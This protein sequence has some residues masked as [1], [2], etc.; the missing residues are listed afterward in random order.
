MEADAFCEGAAKRPEIRGQ[1]FRA[2]EV[3]GVKASRHRVPHDNINEENVPDTPVSA[4][5]QAYQGLGRCLLRQRWKSR[6]QQQ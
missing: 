5:R 1:Q 4:R 2:G 3:C 6:M